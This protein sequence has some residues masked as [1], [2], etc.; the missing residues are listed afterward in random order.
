MS[1]KNRFVLSG[2]IIISLILS[3]F[4]FT[5]SDTPENIPAS[6]YTNDF[7]HQ[8]AI[9]AVPLPKEMSFAGEK[10]P[11]NRND[12]RESIDREFLVNTYWQSQ[13]LL[14]IKRAHKFFPIIT[15]ILRKYNIPDD[16]KYLALI[17][18]GFLNVTSPSGAKGY[19]QFMKGTAKD[20]GLEVNNFVDERMNLE[21][22]TEAACRYLQDAYD[23]FHNWTLAAAAYNTGRSNIQK[24]LDK[25]KVNS[26]YDLYLNSQ[27]AR[28]VFRIIAIKY[29]L[30][31]PE[32]YGFHFRENDLY[33]FPKYD[34]I[35]IDTTIPN[36][37]D[38]SQ[39]HNITYK[40]LK[41]MNPWLY[42]SS[43]PNSSQKVYIFKIPRSQ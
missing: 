7:H 15:P 29:I 33:S 20:Y 41:I 9:Y 26:Y 5:N 38:F 2:I 13:T 16:F 30:S 24:Q 12:I 36:L 32:K 1:K 4:L 37:I 19:W 27:T 43:L 3:L 8:Y 18:S 10:V 22:S 6:K 40:S 39:Q 42:S 35:H 17:E 21:K 11:I 14:F 23:I 25:Q 28:Y 34:T 31:N